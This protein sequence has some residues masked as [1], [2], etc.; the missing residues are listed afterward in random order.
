[1]WGLYAV[2]GVF[3]RGRQKKFYTHR[4]GRQCEDRVE[5]L[6]ILALEDQS[7]V[8]TR[9]EMLAATRRWKK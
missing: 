7:D 2:I 8:A 3:I 9:Q 1:M 4:D 6:T 5:R